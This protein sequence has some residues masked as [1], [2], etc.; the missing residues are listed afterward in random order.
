MYEQMK[1][2]LKNLSSFKQLASLEMN[3]FCR[4]GRVYKHA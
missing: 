2:S 1:G 3:Y 4:G